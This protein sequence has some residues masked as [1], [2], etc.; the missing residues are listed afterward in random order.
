LTTTECVYVVWG[1][2]ETCMPQVCEMSRS[3]ECV[4]VCA[5]VSFRVLMC[6]YVYVC[7]CIHAYMCVNECV[8][9]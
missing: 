5:Y 7:V 3:D 8:S 1:N 6:V 9:V 2:G 4:C